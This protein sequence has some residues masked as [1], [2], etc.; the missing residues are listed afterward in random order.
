MLYIKLN[1]ISVVPLFM[2]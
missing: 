2:F 1:S